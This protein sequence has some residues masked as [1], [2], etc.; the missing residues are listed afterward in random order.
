MVIKIPVRLVKG[1]HNQFVPVF[2]VEIEMGGNVGVWNSTM[3][4][5]IK[6]A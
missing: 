2:F 1:W 3:V 5:F 4:A 6:N